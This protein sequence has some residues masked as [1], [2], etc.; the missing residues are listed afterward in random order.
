MPANPYQHLAEFLDDLP[1]GF[2]R[3]ES[4]VELRILRHLFTP[5]EAGLAVHLALIAEEA[6]DVFTRA[7][8]LI[9]PPKAGGKPRPSSPPANG[10]ESDPSLPI[11]TSSPTTPDGPGTPSNPPLPT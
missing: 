7:V 9:A 8:A 3:S 6:A 11:S 1:A 10:A 5:D 2:P 4:G